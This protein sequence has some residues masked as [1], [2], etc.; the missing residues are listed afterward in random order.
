MQW[1]TVEN[2]REFF[3]YDQSISS[4]QRHLIKTVN[5][6]NKKSLWR[7]IFRFLDRGW[8]KWKYIIYYNIFLH[9]LDVESTK[10]AHQRKCKNLLNSYICEYI[11]QWQKY[12]DL[13]N[14]KAQNILENY[15]QNIQYS[16]FLYFPKSDCFRVLN[17]LFLLTQI[18]QCVHL[19]FFYTLVD[20]LL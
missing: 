15:L 20:D 19:Y 5:N 18:I 10:S 7:N 11:N 14:L 1:D 2:W 13:R 16:V 9:M 17:Y 8:R 4:K 3:H 6:R 12:G